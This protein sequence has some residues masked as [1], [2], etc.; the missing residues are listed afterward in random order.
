VNELLGIELRP[1]EIE[2]YLGQLG[3][4]TVGRKARPVGTDKAA[5]K[6]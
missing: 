6:R 3:L 1:E 2:F 4:E 5:L